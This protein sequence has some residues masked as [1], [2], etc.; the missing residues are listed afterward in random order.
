MTYKEV[1]ATAI[2]NFK[3]PLP[4]LDIQKEI[5]ANIEKLEE[6]INK[7]KEFLQKVQELKKQILNK[8]L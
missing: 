1:S 6:S 5:V 4:P 7:S 8:Y 2:K 3:I